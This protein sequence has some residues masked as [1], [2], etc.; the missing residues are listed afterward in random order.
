VNEEERGGII[1]E[2]GVVDGE[3]AVRCRY[4]EGGHGSRSYRMLTFRG[5]V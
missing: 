5:V 1:L 2:G 4:R 3:E